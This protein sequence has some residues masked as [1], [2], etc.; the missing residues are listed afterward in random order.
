MKTGLFQLSADPIHYGHLAL[1]G[2]ATNE[3]DRLVVLVTSS[4][5]KD[6]TFTLAERTD[7][8]RRAILQQFP[9]ETDTPQIEVIASEA[10]LVDVYLREGCDV[11]IR[12]IRNK[13]DKEFEFRQVMH[14]WRFCPALQYQFIEN[15]PATLKTISSS[16]VKS[17]V[18]QGFDVSE[19]VPL[20]IKS[21]LERR[22]LKQCL[23]G[24]AG[25]TGV[26]KSWVAKHLVECEFW[27][28]GLGHKGNRIKTAAHHINVD[29]LV[30][31][32]LAE[33]S[34]GAQQVR[35][36]ISTLL[37]PEVLT[38]DQK[39]IVREEL[40]KAILGASGDTLVKLHKT[41]APHVHR[42]LRKH[43]RGKQGVILVEWARLVEDCDLTNMVNND[44]ILVDAPDVYRKKFLEARGF[45]FDLLARFDANQPTADQREQELL[46]LIHSD[47]CGF[48]LRYDNWEGQV[49]ALRHIAEFIL[50]QYP[51]FKESL[52]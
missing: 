51:G 5:T 35:D 17:M 45:N 11:L 27:D 8:V 7:M 41:T 10:P 20:F 30:R 25:R 48:C 38:E 36:R 37:G 29:E 12:G 14:H 22:I 49:Q 6:Y 16:S 47:H 32:L 31:E 39:E 50:A 4:A 24:I 28:L 19:L 46:D 3:C 2:L 21:K 23:V 15:V 42:L 34:P 26:G 9:E 52:G 1:I 43:L 40:H 18:A 44:V 33:D 13:Q